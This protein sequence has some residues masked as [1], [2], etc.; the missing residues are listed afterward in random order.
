MG[1]ELCIFSK[2]SLC[3]L[4]NCVSNDFLE[5]TGFCHEGKWK[6]KNQYQYS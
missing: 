3:L 1:S 4:Y 5:D 2:K 6:L